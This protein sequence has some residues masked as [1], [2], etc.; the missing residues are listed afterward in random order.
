MTELLG[1]LAICLLGAGYWHVRRQS[2]FARHWLERYCRR[3]QFQLLSVYRYRYVWKKGRL[4]AQ[5]RFEFSHDGL[6]HNEGDLW[7]HGLKVL[8]VS[9]PVLREPPSPML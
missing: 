9:V 2:E 1:L 3:Q 8:D 7:L 4:L 6:Q 5:F